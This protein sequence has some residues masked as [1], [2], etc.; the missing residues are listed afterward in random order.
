MPE[1][2]MPNRPL[3]DVAP[4]DGPPTILL[5]DDDDQIRL[6]LYIQLEKFGYRVLSMSNGRDA[7][8]ACRQYTSMIALLLTDVRMPDMSGVELASQAALCRPEMSVL[9]SSGSCLSPQEQALADCYGWT[10][11]AK[12]F[13]FAEFQKTVRTLMARATQS[14]VPARVYR[15]ITPGSLLRQ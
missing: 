13:H 12:P 15:N 3:A 9:L 2:R 4:G 10:F 7:L 11:M 5:V 14:R 1:M 6:L 8:L